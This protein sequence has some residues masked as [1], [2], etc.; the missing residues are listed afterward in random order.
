MPSS[1]WPYVTPGIPDHLFERSPGIPITQ[2]ELRLMILSQLQLQAESRLWDIGAGT[3]TIAVESALLCPAGRV[4][5]FERDP[6]VVA[7]IET[8]CRRFELDNVEVIEGNAPDCLQAR[9]DQPTHICVESS[10]AIGPILDAAWE[11]LAEGGRLVATA[12]NLEVLYTISEGLARLHVR[13]VDIVQ[14]S[15]NRLERRGTHQALAAID[16]IFILSGT[17]LD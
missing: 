14:A 13:H 12:S 1:L 5:A 7:L 16:P 4:V 3:G 15:I 10:R 8:N 9:S 6:D 17:K 2:R 11:H